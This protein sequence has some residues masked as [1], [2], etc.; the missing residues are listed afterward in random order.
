MMIGSAESE[1]LGMSIMSSLPLQLNQA[2]A[3][4]R[5]AP[6]SIRDPVNS[7]GLWSKK[8]DRVPQWSHQ[9]TRDF[10]AIRAEL[11]R[12]FTQTK[13]NK[14]LWQAVASKMKERGYRRSPEQCKCKWKNLVN[15]YKG[16]ETSDPE[17]G[18]QCPFYE[19]LQA[20]FTERSKSLNRMLLESELG[21]SAS[22][23]KMKRPLPERSSDEFTDDEEDDEEESEDDRTAT[24]GKK[25][26]LERDRNKVGADKSRANGINEVLQEFFQQQQRMEMQWR[27]MAER[28]AQ[29]R[30]M[31]EQEW[32]QSMEKLE[33][34]RL[35]LEQ[36]YREREEQR[37]MREESRAEKRDQLLTTLLN[38]L[39]HDGL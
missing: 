27:E 32:R 2:A 28:R 24:K 34:E 22:K 4:A 15:R 26:K 33:R 16:K 8:D 38:K 3:M 18:R 37:R 20:I 10:I 25:R 11:E 6:I 12:D 14:T 1:A 17:S 5:E 29:E 21:G 9:E 36:S 30:R 31:F 23:N 39:I 19:E 35:M 13:R 7:S